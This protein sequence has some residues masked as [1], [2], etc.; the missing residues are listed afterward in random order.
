MVNQRKI[1]LLGILFVQIIFILALMNLGMI[2]PASFFR[3]TIQLSDVKPL[4]PIKYPQ[5][6]SA[7]MCGAREYHRNL[8]EQDAAMEDVVYF[9][10]YLKEYAKL[11][12][13]ILAGELPLRVIR[14]VCPPSKYPCEG[15][16]DRI[17]GIFNVIMIALI[18][19]RAFLIGNATELTP[20]STL[21]LFYGDPEVLDWSK[22]LEQKAT[23]EWKCFRKFTQECFTI[24]LANQ[25]FD[26]D[27]V[28][29]ITT[30]VDHAFPMATEFPDFLK[31]S[32]IDRVPFWKSMVM[33]LFFPTKPNF[34]RMVMSVIPSIPVVGIHIRTGHNDVPDRHRRYVE[35]VEAMVDRYMSCIRSVCFGAET[36]DVFA[37]A[38]TPSTLMLLRN[39]LSELGIT[40]IITA[41]GLG[42]IGHNAFVNGS[43]EEESLSLAMRLMV[44]FEILRRVPVIMAARSGF[45]LMAHRVRYYQQT[46]GIIGSDDTC[47][48][49]PTR[50]DGNSFHIMHW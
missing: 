7:T 27:D 12:K 16:G 28:V 35:D 32:P 26:K 36:F 24:P 6:P 47:T 45:S 50:H 14:Y 30:N 23:N 5:F 43:T 13:R 17:K 25:T 21:D 10:E 34:E 44:D 9:W 39:K 1:Y 31:E 22:V 38:D 33:K 2:Q 8:N 18:T 19:K 20:G 42:K 40:E 41:D 37:A 48:R 11:H 15:W 29:D 3:T 4:R 46:I 49:I